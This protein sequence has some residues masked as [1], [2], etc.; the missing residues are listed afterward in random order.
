MPRNYRS[1]WD[2]YPNRNTGE[3]ESKYELLTYSSIKYL[4][5]VVLLFLFFAVL[6]GAGL[7]FWTL[8][9]IFFE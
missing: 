2:K 3:T 9:N 5:I 8:L 4:I 7:G 6:L 1:L